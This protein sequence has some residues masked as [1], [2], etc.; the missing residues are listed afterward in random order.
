[1]KNRIFTIV[2][3]GLFALTLTNCGAIVGGTRQTIRAE[4]SPAAAKL[5]ITPKGLPVSRTQGGQ[6]WGRLIQIGPGRDAILTLTDGT[7]RGGQIVK[8]HSDGLILQVAGQDVAV[9]RSD[10][11]AVKVKRSSGTLTG[12]VVGF[13]ASGI[14]LT[15]IICD[16]NNCSGE[17]WALGI[18][19][20]GVPGGLL[21]VLIGSQIGGDVEIVP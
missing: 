2:V 4:S 13:L 8:V 12:G 20:L 15:A 18:A 5:A 6:G 21:G 3:L 11:A 19:L 16:G 7:L 9:D 14:T 1:M 10:I 17:A